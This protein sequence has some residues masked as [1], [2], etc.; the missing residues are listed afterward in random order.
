MFCGMDLKMYNEITLEV[1]WSLVLPLWKCKTCDSM[2]SIV[3]RLLARWQESMGQI[4]VGARNFS[5]LQCPHWLWGLLSPIQWAPGTLSL[6]ITRAGHAAD[7]SIPSSSKVKKE[8][9]HT[10][11]LPSRHGNNCTLYYDR[12]CSIEKCQ[13]KHNTIFVP[14]LPHSPGLVLCDFFLSQ[15]SRWY[16][17]GWV[18]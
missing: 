17:R 4:P 15:H 3:T 18:W 11:D 12:A 8:W 1:I 5:L 10:P 2:A 16:W 14:Q 13:A 7:P 6:K 9:S